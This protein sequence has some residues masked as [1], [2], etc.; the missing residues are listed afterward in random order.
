MKTDKL[1]K[2]YSK[3]SQKIRRF[4]ANLFRNSKKTLYVDPFAYIMVF[5]FIITVLLDVAIPFLSGGAFFL[6]TIIYFKFFP[7]SWE[8]M[9][10]YEKIEYRK[11]NKL[12]ETWNP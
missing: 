2:K 6:I 7:L 5:L 12:P 4:V 1:L 3:K 11:I 8:E 9:E 10:D